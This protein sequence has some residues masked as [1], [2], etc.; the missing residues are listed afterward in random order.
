MSPCGYLVYGRKRM[1]KIHIIYDNTSIRKDLEA[2]W[3]FAA[4]IE[5]ENKTILF[6]AGSDGHILLGN[7]KK[8]GLDPQKVDTVFISHHH[9]DHTGGLASFLHE[10]PDVDVYV[11]ASLRGIRR[12][13]SITYIDDPIVLSDK[14]YSTGELKSVEQSLVIKT[15]EGSVVIAGCSHPGLSDILE[16]A[17][18]HG[19]IH[20]ALGG[21]HGF[22]EFD[23]LRAVEFVCPT[24]C[25]KYIEK[26][27]K[28][29]PEKYIHGG[30]GCTIDLPI[31]ENQNI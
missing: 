27:K 1:L 11:P 10:N 28:I 16:A 14:I 26:I 12:A 5:T 19:K 17:K 13:K 25:T 21:F 23:A 24:H 20:L 15:P 22:E 8:M 2:D 3:G 31:K 9:F 7:M 4:Y 30:A 18:I 6:D 29:Y